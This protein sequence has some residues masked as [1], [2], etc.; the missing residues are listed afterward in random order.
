MNKATPI[1][2]PQIA[3]PILTANAVHQDNLVDIK[4]IL[5]A[6]RRR[7]WLIAVSFLT[8]FSLVFLLA[9]QQTPI[10]SASAKVLLDTRTAQ[11][12]ENQSVLRDLDTTTATIDTEVQVIRSQVLLEKVVDELDLTVLAEFNPWLQEPSAL[13]TWVD[14]L[15]GWIGSLI[16]GGAEEEV[17]PLDE[18]TEEEWEALRKR[19]A[20]SILQQK[21]S[22]QRIGPTFIIE[23][24]GHS[25]DAGLSAKI[26]NT[27]SDQYRVAQLEAKLEATRR[28]NEWLDERL[29]DLKDEVNVKEAAVVTFRQS[30]DILLLSGTET[31]TQQQI[32]DLQSQKI[33]RQ[34]E[35]DDALARLTNVRAQLANGV[36]PESIGEVLGSATVV[37]L[38]S[39]LAEIRR[40][41]A[42]LATRYGPLFPEI[43][44]VEREEAD[45]NDQV[46]AEVDRIV[47]NLQSEVGIARQRIRALNSSI[48]NAQAN[49]SANEVALVQLQQLERE[50]EA[51]RTLYEEFLNRFKQT[52]E[53]EDLQRSDARMIS[54]AGTPHLPS[55]PNMLLSLAIAVVLGG[56]V[57]GG[58]TLLFETMDNYIATGDEVERAF[59]IPSI[60]AIPLLTGLNVFGK[61]KLSPAD[62]LVENPLSAFAESIRNLRASIIFADLDHAAKTVSISSSLPD[63]GKTSLVYCLGRMSA[64]SGARTI[65]VDGDFRRRQLTEMVGVEPKHGLIEHLFGEVSLDEAIHVDEATGCEILPLTAARNTPRDV[66]GSRAF[67]A[68]IEQLKEHYDLIVIDTGPLLLMAEARVLASKVDQVIMAAKWRSTNRNIMAQAL[69]LL[70]EF[71]ANVAGVVLTFVDMRRRRHHNYGSSNYKAYAKYYTE[72]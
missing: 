20:V 43:A 40:R 16:G 44:S 50:A 3:P 67:D 60:G 71:N 7:I 62:Y 52:T 19:V 42:D 38:R 37:N 26:A 2:F 15:K 34:A 8:V 21:V 56:L 69:G 59:N 1:S 70:K 66:F 9:S 31:L 30:Q 5:A 53:S 65:V 58:L 24:T 54:T 6:V 64:M 29:G 57:A 72:G 35:L 14:G 48:A 41:K 39:Q 22:V 47:S 12:V 4:A 11:I 23:I 68:L 27:V 55:S 63:E 10:Y 61:P 49:F 33:I 17:D 45:L 51:S 36:S 18:L 25:V 46:R 13:E 28:A 32:A